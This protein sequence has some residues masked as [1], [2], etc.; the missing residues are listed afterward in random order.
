[1]DIGI[2]KKSIRFLLCSI[3]CTFAA[4]LHKKDI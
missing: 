4:H 3:I 2:K 1:M